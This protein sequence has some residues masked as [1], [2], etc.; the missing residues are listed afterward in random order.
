MVIFPM[1]IFV[2]VVFFVM[3]HLFHNHNAVQSLIAVIVINVVITD[4]SRE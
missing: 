4:N 3:Y 1:V 2:I